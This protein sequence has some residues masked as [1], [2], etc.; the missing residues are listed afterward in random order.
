VK[1]DARYVLPVPEE[2]VALSTGTLG[3]AYKPDWMSYPVDS[4]Q[5]DP[6]A[7]TPDA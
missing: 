2:L 4:E 5:D 1:K 7:R 3:L 6:K